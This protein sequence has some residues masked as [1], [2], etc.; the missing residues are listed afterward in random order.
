MCAALHHQCFLCGAALLGAVHCTAPCVPCCTALVGRGQWAVDLLQRTATLPGGCGQCNSSYALPHC[1]WAVGSG[2][3][4]IHR[5]TAWGQWAVEILQC[6][7]ARPGGSGQCSSRNALP[8]CLGAVGSAAPAMHCH[9]AWG[10]W[11]VKL[12]QCTAT[13]PEGG[14]Q[15]GPRI[16]GLWCGV[17]WCGVVWCGVV[18]CGVVWCGVVWCGVVW[19]GVPKALLPERQWPGWSC[20]RENASWEGCVSMCVLCVVCCAPGTAGHMPSLQ[21]QPQPKAVQGIPCRSVCWC[22]WSSR[23]AHVIVPPGF[24]CALVRQSWALAC[25]N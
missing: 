17:V 25:A 13:P 21:R 16:A 8:H 19:C 18:W 22:I 20:T 3:P 12:L 10:Q 9:T 15:V 4:A 1:L 7:A 6:N 5:Q 11:A 14:G 2:A 24:V 23:N